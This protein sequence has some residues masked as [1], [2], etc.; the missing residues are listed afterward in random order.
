[1][2]FCEFNCMKNPVFA[3]LLGATFAGAAVKVSG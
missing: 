3:L 1:M 2:R